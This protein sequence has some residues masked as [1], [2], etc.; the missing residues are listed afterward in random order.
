M[1]RMCPHCGQD[2]EGAVPVDHAEIAC[3][4]C[5]KVFGVQAPDTASL[6]AGN[7]T[8]SC[9]PD[10]SDPSGV[11]DKTIPDP[12]RTLWERAISNAECPDRSIKPADAGRRPDERGSSSIS[13][14][15]HVREKQVVERDEHVEPPPDYEL[16]SLLGEGGMGV[17]YQARQTS[18]DRTIALKMIKPG[19]ARDGTERNKFLAEAIATGELD[20]PNIVPIHDLGANRD[21]VLFYAMKEVRGTPWK[22]VLAAKSRDENLDILMRVA[23]AVAF[24]HSKGIIHRDLKPENV[25]LGDYGEV[26]VMDW[27]LAV[28]ITDDAKADKLDPEHAVGGTPCYMPPEMAVGDAEKIGPASDVYLLGA[29]LFEIVTGKRPHPGEHAMACLESAA[30]NRIVGTEADTGEEAAGREELLTIA[31]TAMATRPSERHAGVKGFQASLRQYRTHA[32]SIAIK[33]Q[34]DRDFEHAEVERTYELYSQA[35]FGYRQA[36]KLWTGNEAA[37]EGLRRTRM[38]IATRAFQRGDLDLARSLLDPDNPD[39]DELRRKIDGARRLRATRRRRQKLTRRLAVGTVAAAIIILSLAVV[40]V[41]NAKRSEV[42]QR[43]KAEKALSDYKAEQAARAADRRDSAPSLVRSAKVLTERREFKAALDT[44]Q[45]AVE[46]RPELPD[47]RLVCAVLLFHQG[48]VDPALAEA[49]AFAKLKPEGQDGTTVLRVLR[50]ARERGKEEAPLNLLLPVLGRMGMNM[51]AADLAGSAKGQLEMYRAKLRKAWPDKAAKIDR[52]LRWEKSGLFLDLHREKYSITNVRSLEPLR[53][54]PLGGIRIYRQPLTDLS[55]L[56]GMPL[57]RLEIHGPLQP[58]DLSP[59]EGLPLTDLLLN[60]RNHVPD[61]R[62]LRKLPLKRLHLT[63]NQE[64]NLT[65]L[66]GLQIEHLSLSIFP[67]DSLA[68]LEGMP[69]TKLHLD[70]VRNLSDLT[71]LRGMN[72]RGL[73]L[74]HDPW[75][76]GGRLRSL[77]GLQGM[78]LVRLVLHNQPVNDL[79]PLRG[80]PLED[81]NL[82]AGNCK[83]SIRSLNALQGMPLT[84]LNLRG[85]LVADL[86]ALKGAPLE[87]LV[88]TGTQVTD[89]T[90]LKRMPLKKLAFSPER[91]TNGIEAVRAIESLQ[92]IAGKHREDGKA[93]YLPAAEFWRKYDAGE[94]GPPNP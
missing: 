65:Q 12:V 60:C 72:L 1:D 49:E 76:P 71:P 34:A 73:N 57:K 80:M 85:R 84:K 2:V 56:R 68:A 16:L 7:A 62:P 50:V 6:G 70:K 33:E 61:L 43:H 66:R 47:A 46:Y 41:L 64:L 9:T 42:E 78:P 23:D 40:W 21:G 13:A 19:A 11:S 52:I 90:A 39:H 58:V 79:E 38:T 29:I 93:D 3:P 74:T 20:H 37:A 88:L 81:L 92:Q 35:A 94:F 51:L 15:L 82:D 53:G 22:D 54:I 25:M 86:A 18:I 59:L 27:G 31:L 45:T 91:V 32:E 5:G 24:A 69:L 48:K 44:I 10:G 14:R 8:L 89:L 4:A 87:E 28:A 63:C 30:L 55:P 17:V 83:P 36:L 26:L 67:V 75:R 77:D